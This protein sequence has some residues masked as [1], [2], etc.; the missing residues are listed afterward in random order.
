LTLILKIILFCGMTPRGAVGMHKCHRGT[1]CLLLLLTYKVNNVSPCPISAG[2]AT[3]SAFGIYPVSL[4]VDSIISII[5]SVGGF[6]S[7][8]VTGSHI[9]LRNVEGV[10]A[11]SECADTG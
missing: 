10:C 8:V 9:K 7:L 2:L 1:R 6:G 4:V 3:I 5:A 11:Y